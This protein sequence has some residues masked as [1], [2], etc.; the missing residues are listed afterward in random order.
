MQELFSASGDKAV[1]L[2][3]TSMRSA[4]PGPP[5]TCL[6][7][8]NTESPFCLN[9]CQEVQ[10]ARARVLNLGFLSTPY[11]PRMLR[12]LSLTRTNPSK[13]EARPETGG[14][15][16]LQAVCRSSRWP[17]GGMATTNAN[18]EADCSAL[19]CAVRCWMDVG[20]LQKLSRGKSRETAGKPEVQRDGW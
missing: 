4:S 6:K 16:T 1:K 17:L 14:A 12:Q 3:P 13:A 8:P 11:T 10:H 5:S 15:N 2:G 7:P 9:R 20:G 19:R 18:K